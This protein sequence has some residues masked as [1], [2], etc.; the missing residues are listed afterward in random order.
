LR[1]NDDLAAVPQEQIL[2]EF[3]PAFGY[4]QIAAITEQKPIA[5]F[6]TDDIP[7][8]AAD[9]R[10]TSC[11]QDHRDNVEIV[12]GSSNDRRGNEHGLAGERKPDAFEP[13]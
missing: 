2:T 13:D 10:R 7:N 4:P 12:L 8:H 1:E 6:T 5:K 9:D 11:S 3:D